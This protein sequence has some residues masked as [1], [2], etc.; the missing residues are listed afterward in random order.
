MTNSSGDISCVTEYF[1]D[2]LR[3]VRDPEIGVNVVDLGMIYA[4]DL[5]NCDAGKFEVHIEMTLTSPACPLAEEI[6]SEIKFTI[7]NTGKC[8]TVDVELVFDPPWNVDM[9]TSEG[10]MQ[11]GL[12]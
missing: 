11:L 3:N 12:L 9:I 8:S 1:W 10:K 7:A 2:V 4:V 6:I 5:G